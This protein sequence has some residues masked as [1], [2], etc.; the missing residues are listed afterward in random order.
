MALL[1]AELLD[2]LGVWATASMDTKPVIRKILIININFFIALKFF[3]LKVTGK[4]EIRPG[5]LM[6]NH[7]FFMHGAAVAF[8]A[9]CINPVG[10]LLHGDSDGVVHT[11]IL[12]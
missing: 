2:E 10:E 12:L 8:R 5:C 11:A 1:P 4:T 6:H 7:Y 9:K 3:G